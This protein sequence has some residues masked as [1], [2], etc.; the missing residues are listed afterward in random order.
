MYGQLCLFTKSITWKFSEFTTV[1]NARGKFYQ[2]NHKD[3]RCAISPQT[4]SLCFFIMLSMS[5]L[6]THWPLKYRKGLADLVCIIT[7]SFETYSIYSIS[8]YFPFS[9]TLCSFLALSLNSSP[10]GCTSDS[11]SALLPHT[12]HTKTHS[13]THTPALYSNTHPHILVRR[14]YLLLCCLNQAPWGLKAHY[15]Q[16]KR[17]DVIR[18]LHVLRS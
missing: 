1:L 5:T 6:Q 15:S 3:S 7:V 9:P 12:Q 11:A 4:L 17:R 13:H 10:H 14:R 8:L 2:I 16:F 18:I